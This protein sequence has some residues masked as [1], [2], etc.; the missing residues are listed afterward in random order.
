MNKTTQNTAANQYYQI[1]YE[2]TP[3]DSN[4]PVPK[5]MQNT[6]TNAHKQ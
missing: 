4:Y 5:R 1:G 2:N 3:S 6:S